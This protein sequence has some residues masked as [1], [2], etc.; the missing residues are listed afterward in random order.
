MQ[1]QESAGEHQEAARGAGARSQGAQPGTGVGPRGTSSAS[2]A[3]APQPAGALP[4][5]V[6]INDD[7]AAIGR[8]EDEG[9]DLD[10]IAAHIV[11]GHDMNVVSRQ[12]S[13]QATHG[14]KTMM[15]GEQSNGCG[16]RV[17]LLTS[18]G[19]LVQS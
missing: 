12:L 15:E 9:A 4:K 6:D 8:G 17:R 10:S 19:P 16:Y 13:T 14:K 18:V 2:S 7:N 5:P 1:L 11:S 3:Q